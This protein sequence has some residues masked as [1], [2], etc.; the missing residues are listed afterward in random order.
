MDYRKGTIGRVFTVRFDEG[1][2]FLEGLLKI[3]A[4]EKIS[5][6]W[7]HVLGGL[8]EADVVTGP[9]EPVMPPEPVW[10]EVRGARETM[11][12]GSIFWDDNEPKIH[13]HAAMGHHGETL[14]AC[15]R[16][17]TKVYL[18][19]EVVIFEIEGIN[20]S[21]PWYEEGGFNRLT[22]S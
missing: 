17:G 22:F 10:S 11:G 9:K 7:F 5:S 20:A 18:V 14:T 19:L 21:R 8:R 2:L 13:L 3:I 16:K 12:T 15:V 6:G 1:D 4:E